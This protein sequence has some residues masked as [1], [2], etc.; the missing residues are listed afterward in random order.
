MQVLSKAMKELA[1]K[2]EFR[3]ALR[4]LLEGEERDRE[5][6]EIEEET[7]HHKEKKQLVI[8]RITPA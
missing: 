6:F 2:G 8:R 7:A 3:K 5:N 4:A 1:A